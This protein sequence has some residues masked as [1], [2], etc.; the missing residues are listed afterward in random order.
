MPEARERGEVVAGLCGDGEQEGRRV[1]ERERG[2]G[3]E[4]R[5]DDDGLRDVSGRRMS[6]Y[7]RTSRRLGASRQL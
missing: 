6:T 2:G 3:G 4:G 5:V 7:W 1:Q